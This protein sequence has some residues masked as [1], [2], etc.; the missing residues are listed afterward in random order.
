MFQVLDTYVRTETRKFPQGPVLF[1]DGAPLH[2]TFTF[3]S[4]LD[5]LFPNYVDWKSW[6]KRLGNEIP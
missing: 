1:Q 4:L 2:T 5:V 3:S 6:I